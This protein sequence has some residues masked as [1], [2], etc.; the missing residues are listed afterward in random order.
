[1]SKLHEQS[2]NACDMISQSRDTNQYLQDKSTSYL[3]DNPA[4]YLQDNRASHLQDNPVS[5][6]QDD[7]GILF[8]TSDNKSICETMMQKCL[9]PG[10]A[11][12]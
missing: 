2:Q 3:Q 10:Y 8:R 12:R 9:G 7:Y 11:T 1:M 5:Y 4:S 6:L